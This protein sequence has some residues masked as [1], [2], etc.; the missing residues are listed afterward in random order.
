MTH[1]AIYHRLTC[2]AC[3]G[4]LTEILNLGDLRLNAFPAHAWEVEQVHRV[5]LVL[6]VCTGCGLVQL[7]R[8]VPADW[9]YREY[10]YRSSVNETMVQELTTIVEEACQLVSIDATNRVLDIGANDGTLLSAYE[11]LK[12][13]PLRV[14]VEPAL[15][16]QT[17]LAKHADV[18]IPGY[19]P[20]D[21]PTGTFAIITAIAM[22]YDLE[23]PTA[24]FRS[25]HDHLA[26]NGVAV[27]QFQD[28]GQQIECAA[29]DNVCHE[30]LEYYTLWSLSHLCRT[31][32]LT[33]QRVVR[34]PING[35]SLRVFLRRI[36]DGIESEPSVAYQLLR[37]AQQG[38]DTPHIREGH[39]EAFTTFRTRVER[40]KTQIASAVELAQEQGCVIDV[41][42]ASTKGNILLQVLGL[43]PQHIRQAIERSPE[44]VGRYTVTGIPIVSEETARANPAGVWLVPLWQFKHFIIERESEYLQ[45]GGTMIFPLPFTDVIRSGLEG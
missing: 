14:A 24:F 43:G 17:T 13:I 2:R 9:M 41:Y 28:L 39:L 23:D 22:C 29:F 42:G 12:N 35:G 25:I 26:M 45:R 32:G 10:W 16:L 27:V 38:L 20:Q 5:P 11:K 21:A 36:E 3:R 8:T 7:D 18:A 37:E 30:H 44:K 34:T 4:S 1:P 19:F 31:T 33:M 15:N 6:T 40:A